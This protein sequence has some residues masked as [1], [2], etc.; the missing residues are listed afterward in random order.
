MLGLDAV[1]GVAH[2]AE[3]LLGAIRDGRLT[4]RRDLV[5]VLLA[6]TE[7][8]GR[9]LPGVA[10]PGGRGRPGGVGRRA[11][12]RPGRG[13][14]GGGAPARRGP[15]R[16]EGEADGGAAGHGPA[17]RARRVRPRAD[18]A[19]ARPARRRRRGRARRPP[20]GAAASATCPPGGRSTAR[21]STGCAARCS[22]ARC[23]PTWRDAVHTLVS[24]DD[25]LQ[26]RHP[27]AAQRQRGRAAPASRACATAR[28]GS[29]WSRSAGSSA[30]FPQLVREVAAATGK[31]VAFVVDGDDVELD[32]RVLDGVADALRHL[33][34]N[35]VDHGCE[36]PEA[37][38]AAGKP[39]QAA[40]TAQRPRLG[41]RGGHRGVRR[42]RGHRRIGRRGRRP[43]RAGC[44]PRT[45]RCPA[46]R[47]SSCSS[48][49]GFT[50][51]DE[52]TA[53]VRPRRRARRRPHRGRG[54]RRLGRG[55]APSSARAPPSCMTLPVT[56]GVM[57]CLVAR[58]GD[59]RYAAAVTAHVVET[60]D[61]AS[62]TAH[63]RRRGARCV[64]R[65]GVHDPVGRPGRRPSA[66]RG[67]GRRAPPS[68]CATGRP[69][70]SWPGRSTRWRASCELVVKDLGGFLGRLRHVTGAT[71][72]GDGQRGA[73]ARRPRARA[74]RPGLAA[75]A[76]PARRRRR[77][78]R[79]AAAGSRPRRRGARP[80]VLVVEDSIG[81]R[82]LQRV[83]LEGA[84]YDVQTAVDG[85]R[86]RQPP[87]RGAG[88]PR[89]LRRRDARAW[90]ASR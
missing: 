46:S 20:D 71:I 88:R 29:P 67:S 38:R 68:W 78:S 44:S 86:R 32:T 54:P 66:L 70:S 55:P 64:V 57:R 34:T 16:P 90:T 51:R 4:V 58:V 13:G 69:T 7:G 77:A 73:A 14:P 43:S 30:A 8:I 79:A 47:C 45:P 27:R 85:A 37:R 3:D 84:G 1:V 56:L 59:E 81:V 36:S 18:P 19:G 22:T 6:A 33:V 42:R 2:R 87:R 76:P 17:G 74:V 31:D 41:G 12:L 72:D 15:G 5:D 49:P 83:I 24:L 75:S 62:V 35:A 25:R 50:T 52:V 60:F 82:E 80:R 63:V 61:L 53:D 10:S 21:W 26:R 9:A 48:P 28:W 89:A 40:V 39:A 65:H 23:G 11:G